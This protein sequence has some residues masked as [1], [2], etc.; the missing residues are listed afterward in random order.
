MAMEEVKTRVRNEPHV[1]AIERDQIVFVVLMALGAALAGRPDW[2]AGVLVG[3]ILMIVNFRLLRNILEQ[4]IFHRIDGAAQGER[5]AG[6][7][8][9][10]AKLLFKFALL[11]GVVATVLWTRIV[12]L[13]PF[14]IGTT[15]L[16]ASIA[17]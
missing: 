15:A 3:G 11:A 10:V 1:A 14:V 7:G 9:L 6:A 13:V 16:L 2:T 8:L 12:P 4:I 17:L 5:S